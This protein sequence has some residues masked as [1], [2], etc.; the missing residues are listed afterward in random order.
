[1][2]ALHTL[3]IAHNYQDHKVKRLN[4]QLPANILNSFL[5]SL[6]KHNERLE[7]DLI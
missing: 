7:N 3:S 1:M 6:H 2:H 5:G 4:C